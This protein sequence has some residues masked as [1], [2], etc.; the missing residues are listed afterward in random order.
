MNDLELEELKNWTISPE[1]LSNVIST[2]LDDGDVHH[3]E[4]GDLGG[5]V[6]LSGSGSMVGDLEGSLDREGQKDSSLESGGRWRK[7]SLNIL[8]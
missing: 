1:N 3:F 2:P 8:V 6:S 7:R 5:N 4:L